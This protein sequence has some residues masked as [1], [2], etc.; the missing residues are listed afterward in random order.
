MLYQGELTSLRA[1]RDAS[2]ARCKALAA[3]LPGAIDYDFMWSDLQAKVSK[4]EAER[5]AA[6]A[7]AKTNFELYQS[8]YKQ[9]VALEIELKEHK[10]RTYCAYCGYAIGMDQ[11]GQ[12]IADHIATCEKHPMQ[13]LAQAANKL[14]AERDALKARLEEAEK[15]LIGEEGRSTKDYRDSMKAMFTLAYQWQDKKHRYVHDLCNR[16]DEALKKIKG[17]A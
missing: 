6:L 15:I 10:G 2:N 4:A 12:L 3:K 8:H 5:D 14:E 7:D 9:K 11:D 13:A 17:E 16:I 1:E